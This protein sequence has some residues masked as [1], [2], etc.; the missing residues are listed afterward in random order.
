MKFQYIANTRLKS[1]RK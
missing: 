1:C